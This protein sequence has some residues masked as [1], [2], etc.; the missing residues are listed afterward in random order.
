M[1]TIKCL[2][3]A[4]LAAS[5][6]PAPY[7][8]ETVAQDVPKEEAPNYPPQPG[9]ALLKFTPEEIVEA[10]KDK[11]MPEAVRMY[12]AIVE[13]S[14]MDGSSGWFGP[15][16]TRYTWDWLKSVQNSPDAASLPAK[17]F[18]GPETSFQVLDRNGDGEIQADDLDWDDSNPWVQQSYMINRLFRRID[19]DGD[20]IVSNAEWNS[21]YRSATGGDEG[22]T[23]EQLRDKML[24][25]TSGSFRPGDAPT[26]DILLKGLMAGEIGSLQEGPD[27]GD[28]APDF[29]LRLADGSGTV[30]LSDKL[31]GKPVVLVFGN[32]TCGPFRSMYPG[33]DKL[34]EKYSD[35]AVFL[36]VYVREAHPTD[37][38]AM[39]SN[40]S[41][42]VTIEQ[43]KTFE[44]RRSV[45]TT[46]A[47]KL[48]MRIPLLVDDLDDTVGNTYS[49]MPARLY[50][51]DSQGRVAYKSGRGPFGFKS[52]EMEQALQMAILES[53]VTNMEKSLSG[54]TNRESKSVSSYVGQLASSEEVWKALPSSPLEA[55]EEL[56]NWAR[57]LGTTLPMTTAAMLELDYEYRNTK[58]LSG[59]LR[60]LVRLAVARINK[61]TYGLD[62][63][64]YE[65]TKE[66]IPSDLVKS[67][68][69]GSTQGLS[70]QERTI[71]NFCEQLTRRGSSLSEEDYNLTASILSDREMV[72][73]VLLIAY[74]NFQDRLVMALGVPSETT[75]A[76]HRSAPQFPGLLAYTKS[77]APKVRKPFTNDAVLD[78]H[79]QIATW[80]PVSVEIVQSSLEHQRLRTPRI[81]IPSWD[82]IKNTLEPGMYNPDRPL[83]I[84]WSR[85]VLGKQPELGSAWIKCLRVFEAE[86]QQDR[87]FEESVFWVVTKELGCFYC[88]GHCE[89]LMEVGGLDKEQ[90]SE[91]T[92][93]LSS[94]DLSAFSPQEIASFALAEKMT[95][96]PSSVRPDD[97]KGIEET[98]GKEEAIHLVWWISRCQF[99]TKVSDAFQLQL[100]NE[101][102]F[103]DFATVKDRD[104][105]R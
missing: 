57:A 94:V 14:M 26:K 105:D 76:A 15:A 47:T 59:R 99:M 83:E 93:L 66:G 36:G 24:A 43:P 81:N 55:K 44:E 25:R 89:M 104:T 27:L 101:N 77:V 32:F 16:Q 86:A 54:N 90:I 69:S 70:P 39:S 20:G 52:G 51:L 98:L 103:H 45:A 11:R 38:W 80:E 95:R 60:G 73:L 61:S 41:A 97:I 33:V 68:Q 31:D 63:A 82:E 1:K 9:P 13:G 100:E 64:A 42:G 37:G 72:G 8:V 53:E 29:E 65:L 18:V 79:D 50:V 85:L 3:T 5:C 58:E 88:M 2:L 62:V 7:G 71:V 102:V 35:K 19:G 67:W 21:L 91:R 12:L 4:M 87:V 56:P 34:A 6:M 78:T 74:A 49:G 84:R 46:C 10:Y 30:K 17:D 75:A 96:T 22:L 40:E 28:A 23:F 48:K 92:K